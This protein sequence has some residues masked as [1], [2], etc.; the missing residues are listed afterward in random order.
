VLVRPGVDGDDARRPEAIGHLAE[1][2]GRGE[3]ERHVRLPVGV[4]RDAD[5]TRSSVVSSAYRPSA[6]WTSTSSSVMPK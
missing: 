3:V 4:D 1:E 6:T 2:L 5:R